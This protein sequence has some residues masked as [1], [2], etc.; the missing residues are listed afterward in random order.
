MTMKTTRVLLA[1]DHALV[2]AGIRAL[3]EKM[4]GIEVVAEA[5]DGREALELIKR[6]LP[7][8]V[9]MDIALPGLNGLEALARATKEFRAVKVI[10]LSMHANKEYVLQA[11]R[12]GA[13]GYLL[14]DAAVAELEL[15]LRAVSC[16][17][18]YLSPRIS[19]RVIDSYLER[20]AIERPVREELTSRQREIVQLIAE[21]ENTKEIAFLLKVSVKTVEAHRA[22]LMDRLGI[23][24]VAGLVRYA[25][26]V[27]LVP[28][29]EGLQA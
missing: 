4:T 10:I 12:A 6:Q 7:H 11:L 28:P 25:M 13:C 8:V 22:Q 16:G 9:F 27:G 1:D 2:R 3:L 29:E 18:T 24:H 21:G 26:R 17:E 14:M 15:A 19:K 20:L 23:H 5:G